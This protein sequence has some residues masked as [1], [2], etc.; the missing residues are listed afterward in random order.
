MRSKQFVKAAPLAVLAVMVSV[1]FSACDF[2]GCLHTDLA[3]LAKGDYSRIAD[4]DVA[5]TVRSAIDGGTAE[6]TSGD[7]NEDGKPELILLETTR[8]SSGGPQPILAVFYVNRGKIENAILD[9]N[10]S[11]EYFFLGPDDSVVYFFNASGAV[12]AEQYYR[13]AFTDE[14]DHGYTGGL[15]AANFLDGTDLNGE[16]LDRESWAR[17]HPDLADMPLKG[18]HYIRLSSENGEDWLTEEEIDE[19]IFLAEYKMLTGLDFSG[20]DGQ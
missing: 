7:I 9:F 10:D 19:Q 8:Q 17:E 14:Y 15:V 18:V 1:L 4:P 2:G 16:P 6:W 11:T 5:Q 20:R 12:I 3:A 13:C